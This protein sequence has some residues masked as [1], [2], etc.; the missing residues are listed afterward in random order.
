MHEAAE[1][2]GE[3]ATIIMMAAALGM[4]AFSLG[5]GIGMKGVR[6]QE[7]VRISAVIAFFH[8]LMPLLGIFTGEYLGMLLGQ[9]AEYVSGGLLI[10][11]GIHMIVSSV[12]GGGMQ[13]VNTR[14][15]LGMILFAMSVSVDSFSVGVSLGMFHSNLVL[16]VLAFGFFGG[17]MS[18]M[19]LL[20]GRRVSHSLGDYGEAVGGA[21]L[22]A[23]GLMFIF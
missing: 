14:T 21:V 9:V 19:G 8:I 11:L 7:V 1:R 2:L 5:I 18:V 15:F 22:L 23:F 16:T 6:L 17:L 3:L 4:D 10:L 20:L 12:R 13:V